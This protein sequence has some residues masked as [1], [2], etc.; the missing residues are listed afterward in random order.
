MKFY[1]IKTCGTCKRAKKWLEEHGLS[2]QEIDLKETAPSKEELLFAMEMSKLELKKFFNTSGQLY[3]EMNIKEKATSL[4]R[5]EVADL[6]VSYPMLIKRPLLIEGNK[7]LV[8]FSQE[9]Y[10][11]LLNEEHL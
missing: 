5:E 9:N 4:T 1:C 8:G 10:L 11:G 3:R 7:V 6:L 2:F